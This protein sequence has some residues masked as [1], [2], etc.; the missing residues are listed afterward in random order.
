MGFGWLFIGYFVAMLMTF[1]P[2]G[3]AIRLI[4]YTMILVSALKL[5]RYQSAFGWVALGSC[6]MVG[7]SVGL[8]F[9]DISEYLYQGMILDT[10]LVSDF[11]REVLGHVE[12]GALLI[13]TVLLLLAIRKIALETEVRKISDNAV[14]NLMFVGFYYVVYVIGN[15]P[16]AWV[17]NLLTELGIISLILYFAWII[18]NLILIYSCYANICDEGDVEMERKPSRFAF[19]NQFR[20]ENDARHQK[21][22]EDGEALRRARMERR[23]KRRNK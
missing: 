9:A 15:L 11:I 4:G 6:L 7:V 17:K 19:V 8:A 22:M 5:R 3:F 14:R 10:K 20:E 12:R 13:F 18:L 21:A 1:N 23:K 2:V 16:F